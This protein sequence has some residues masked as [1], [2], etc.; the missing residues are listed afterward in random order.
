MRA[1]KT[2]ARPVRVL[3]KGL[4]AA[5]LIAIYLVHT[6]GLL[7][8]LRNGR[9]K[10]R[11]LARNTSRY[12]RLALSLLNVRVTTIREDGPCAGADS[13]LLV[14]ANHV[15]W[16]DIL[17]LSSFLPS[18]FVTSVELKH[19]PFLGMLARLSGC[20]FVE[21]RSPSGIRR[22]IGEIAGVLGNGGRVV[23]FP[24][25]TTS[26]GT[27]VRPFKGSLFDTAFRA[28]VRVQ[29][30]CLRYRRIDAAPIVGQ[31]RDRI[32]YYG[33]VRLFRHLLR[34][35]SLRSVEVE[36]VLLRSLQ[37]RDHPTRKELARHAHRL[38]TAAYHAGWPAEANASPGTQ[39]DGVPKR[40]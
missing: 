15:S 36:I 33:G 38:I 19:S 17:V 14:V 35:L 11:F 31:N 40:P 3:V 20:L 1:R 26:N 24:E 32:F 28:E 25:G 7:L 9:K 27:S 30:V 5:F 23:L 18:L 16:V 8:V 34:V 29:P 2:G 10:V 37:P 4:S 13:G 22:E 39:H 12:A 21:R 6:S